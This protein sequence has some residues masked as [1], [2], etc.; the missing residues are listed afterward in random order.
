MEKLQLLIAYLSFVIP[1]AVLEVTSPA[2]IFGSEHDSSPDAFPSCVE[3]DAVWPPPHSTLKPLSD[4]QKPL[5]HY[6]LRIR[7]SKPVGIE[8]LDTTGGYQPE[9]LNQNTDLRDGN[10]LSVDYYSPVF[11]SPSPTN[12]TRYYPHRI[13]N[14]HGSDRTFMVYF[15]MSGKIARLEMT[16]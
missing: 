13:R 7:F 10:L 6:V 3:V 14:W 9:M 4:S 12:L 2:K 5:V 8:D 15:V 11:L 1:S 16:E